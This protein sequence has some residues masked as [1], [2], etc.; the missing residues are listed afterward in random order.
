M[1]MGQAIGAY[2][3][4]GTQGDTAPRDVDVRRVQARLLDA[5]CPLY[6]LYDVPAGHPLF[7]PTQELALAGILR[8]DDPTELSPDEPIS[9]ARARTWADRAPSP[10]AVRQDGGP[11]RP[12]NVGDALRPHLPATDPVSRGAFVEALHAAAL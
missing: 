6:I 9:A 8:D 2:A 4:L 3:A 5:G 10:V 7:R 1:L 12:G 11:L